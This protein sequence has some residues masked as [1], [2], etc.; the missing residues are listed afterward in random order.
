MLLCSEDQ[1]LGLER[2]SNLTRTPGTTWVLRV[3][4]WDH[5]GGTAYAEYSDF[6][7][8]NEEQAYQLTV[9]HYQG[10]AGMAPPTST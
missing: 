2:V 10:N 5:E 3:D 4:L 6:R 7:L 8:A 9:G 1:W